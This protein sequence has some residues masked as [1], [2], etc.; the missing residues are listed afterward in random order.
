[1]LL[2]GERYENVY[3]ERSTNYLSFNALPHS[4]IW[5]TIVKLLLKLTSESHVEP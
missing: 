3:T 1:M 4:N 2:C 5:N